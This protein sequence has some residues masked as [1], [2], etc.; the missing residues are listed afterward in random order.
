M[1]Y[2]TLAI[3]VVIAALMFAIVVIWLGLGSRD[4]K[5]D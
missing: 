1:A 4:R 2:R 3:L 5:S